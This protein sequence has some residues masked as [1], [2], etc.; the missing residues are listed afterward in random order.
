[1]RYSRSGAAVGCLLPALAER[2]VEVLTVRINTGYCASPGWSRFTVGFPLAG[3][4]TILGMTAGNFPNNHFRQHQRKKVLTISF[5]TELALSLVLALVL[6][7][8]R[9]VQLQVP[10]P[11]L[12]LRLLLLFLPGTQST[13]VISKPTTM[14]SAAEI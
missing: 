6:A 13:L 4:E 7:L 8:G 9:S 1:M 10:D 14:F 2:S 12:P 5:P 11:N 3:R